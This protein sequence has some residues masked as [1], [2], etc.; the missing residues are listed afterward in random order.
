MRAQALAQWQAQTRQLA[1]RL[2]FLAAFRCV[3]ALVA[4]AAAV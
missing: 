1:R 2:D 4:G 3:V